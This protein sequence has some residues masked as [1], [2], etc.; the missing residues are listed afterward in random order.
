MAI[1]WNL[2]RWLAVE[3]NIYRPGELRAVLAERADYHLTIQAV[4]TLM[5]GPP[6]ELRLRTIQALCTS[7]D[8]KLSDFCEVSPGDQERVT[9]GDATV[10]STS[11]HQKRVSAQRRRQIHFPSPPI[12]SGEKPKG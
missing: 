11:K 6:R 3:R 2:R 1:I 8:C 5:K 7:L 9:E 4:T 12:P 10:R